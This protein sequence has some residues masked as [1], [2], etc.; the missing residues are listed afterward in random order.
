MFLP[1]LFK[2]FYCFYCTT[3]EQIPAGVVFG[4][5]KP[6]QLTD[7]SD[8]QSHFSNFFF[9]CGLRGIFHIKLQLVASSAE[10]KLHCRYMKRCVG[11]PL[12]GPFSQP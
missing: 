9:F 12:D 5:L 1:T 3:K 8:K 11:W 6:K 4:L 10:N 2:P 7:Q